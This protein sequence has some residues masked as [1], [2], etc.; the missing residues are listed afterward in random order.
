MNPSQRR[1]RLA[2]K[3]AAAGVAVIA[4]TVSFHL[5]TVDQAAAVSTAIAAIAALWEPSQA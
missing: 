4:C 2:Q 5:L 3:L 1:A